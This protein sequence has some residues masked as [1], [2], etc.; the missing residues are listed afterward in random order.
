[1]LKEIYETF[2]L[3]LIDSSE[4]TKR[5]LYQLFDTARRNI[6]S[7]RQKER[8]AISYLREITRSIG[9]QQLSS[10]NDVGSSSPIDDI[11]NLPKVPAAAAANVAARL[12]EPIKSHRLSSEIIEN[13]V[14]LHPQKRR[15]TAIIAERIAILLD[16]E[17]QKI[18]SSKT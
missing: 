4:D 3:L 18:L 6:I 1:M 11:S 17:I 2:Q 5:N 13:N 12:N 15:N 10:T 14:V 7:G 9:S 8:L 16:I